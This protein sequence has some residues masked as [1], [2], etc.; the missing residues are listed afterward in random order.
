MASPR[1][2]AATT[3]LTIAVTGIA[4]AAVARDSITGTH[5]RNNTIAGIDIQNESLTGAD[6]KNGSLRGRDLLAN[7]VGGN[8]ILESTL[9]K[10]PSAAAA[11]TATT[12]TSAATATNA[13]LADRAKGVT[14]INPTFVEAFATTDQATGRANAPLITLVDAGALKLQGKCWHQSD[15]DSVS[16]EVYVRTSL[17][18]AVIHSSLPQYQGGG[19]VNGTNFLN[20]TTTLSNS[21][22]IE[23]YQA[24]NRFYLTHY[25]EFSASAPDGSW[26]SGSVSSLV[27]NGT[28]TNAP[29]TFYGSEHSCAFY[30]L[31]G[32]SGS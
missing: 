10:V 5:V 18:A 26:L 28:P 13:T 27:R 31:I 25:G 7:S 14:R 4:Y 1:N 30:G 21:L 15:S 29:A 19:V 16:S 2:L 3:I 20:T 12:A 6:V 22:I 23:N 11:D 32:H 8:Q 9:S 24:N 17:D